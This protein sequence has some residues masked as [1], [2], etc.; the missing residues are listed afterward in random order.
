MF[1][2]RAIDAREQAV[3]DELTEA[4]TTPTGQDWDWAQAIQDELDADPE[5]EEDVDDEDTEKAFLPADLLESP[6]ASEIEVLEMGE[7]DEED[8][9]A[10]RIQCTFQ[11]VEAPEAGAPELHR[12]DDDAAFP[13]P[14]GGLSI[15]RARTN[16]LWVRDDAMV[17][18][19]HCLLFLDDD[20]TLHIVD[21]G[22][23]TGTHVNG[24]RVIRRQLFGGE[25]L[26]IGQLRFQLHWTGASA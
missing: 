21:H 5:A 25:R 6:M 14:P 19:K 4:L 17:S 24:E 11:P 8:D 26:D 1:G 9:E 23:T 12:I 20:G 22:S 18:R 2:F 15:G 7:A 3:L 16:D 10:P 13:M